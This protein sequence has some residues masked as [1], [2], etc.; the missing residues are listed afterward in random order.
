[1]V[2]RQC[3]ERKLDSEYLLQLRYVLAFLK[4]DSGEMERLVSASGGDPAAESLLLSSQADTE[5]WYGRLPKAR[6]LFRRAL[7][8]ARRAESNETAALLQVNTALLEAEFGAPNSSRQGALSAL[9]LASNRIVKPRAALALARARD[10][11]QARKLA[12]TLDKE[13]PLDTIV[14]RYW[15]PVIRS[16]IE[17]NRRDAEKA[18]EILQ[19]TA[20][21][22]LA[23]PP[24]LDVGTLYPVYLRGQ[25]YLHAGKGREAAAEFQKFL[26]HRGLVANY[27]LGALAH[28]GLANPAML[29]R[30]PAWQTCRR[31]RLKPVYANPSTLA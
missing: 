30:V 19:V 3:E 6:E 15:L 1:L 5:A 31:I 28:L 22:E 9:G 12:D 16:A 20:P 8:S 17:L 27:P 11:V 26:D 10:A 21:Y 4:G 24:P 23:L 25:A 29:G 14:Q 18:L 13:F 2:S 7:D